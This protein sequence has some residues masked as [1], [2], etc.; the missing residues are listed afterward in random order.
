M[1]KTFSLVI[2]SGLLTLPAVS[3]AAL[4]DRGGGLIYDDILD[5]TWLKDANYAKT[6]GYD[7]DGLFNWSSAKAWAS[8]L[9]YY[10]SVR[11]VSY[12]DW[13]LPSVAPIGNSFVYLIGYNGLSDRGYGI[14]SPNSELAHLWSV[15]LGNIGHCGPAS[16]ANT[17]GCVPQNGGGLQNSGPFANLQDYLYWSGSDYN[18]A[19][20]DYWG[21]V[22]HAQGGWQDGLRDYNEIYA[23]AVRDGDVAASGQTP[24]PSTTALLFAAIAGL[25]ASHRRQASA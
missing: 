20:P 21:W 12:D 16:D 18:P 8:N 7:T 3:S 2:L 23:W 4:V 5:V 6:S 17:D 14:T 1:K 24:E 15:S 9:N 22:F 13:R 19:V 25:F 10:D 11:Q